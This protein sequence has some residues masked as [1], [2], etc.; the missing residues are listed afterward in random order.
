MKERKARHLSGCLSIARSEAQY[1]SHLG[2][3]RPRDDGDIRLMEMGLEHRE[4]LHG[5]MVARDDD[6]RS[7]R[8]GKANKRLQH[9]TQRRERW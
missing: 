1:A 5:I 8:I 7:A 2:S 9:E 6:N 4:Q 3:E